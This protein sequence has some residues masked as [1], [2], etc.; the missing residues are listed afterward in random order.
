MSAETPVPAVLVPD[1]VVAARE[2][3]GP[4]PSGSESARA[5]SFPCR[6]TPESTP[7]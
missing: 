3:S 1:A 7:I 4:E 2:V 6:R 5:G